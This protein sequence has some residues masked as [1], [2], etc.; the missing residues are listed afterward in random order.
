[1]ID[2]RENDTGSD[3]GQNCIYLSLIVNHFL[4]MTNKIN[5]EKPSRVKWAYSAKKFEGTVKTR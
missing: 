5:C 1:M 2:C 4:V 3:I